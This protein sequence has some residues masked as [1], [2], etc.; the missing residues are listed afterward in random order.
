MTLK[1]I[2]IPAF[3]DNYIWAITDGHSV[4]VVDPGDAEP[5][6]KFCDTHSVCITAILL[7][8]HHEDH[9]GGVSG[10]LSSGRVSSEV[11]VYGPAMEHIEHV[12]RSLQ[13][14][15]LVVVGSPRFS[16]RVLDVP[17]HTSGHI[18]YFQ[19]AGQDGTP[20]LFCG[21]TLFA[22]GCGRLFEGTPQQ[23]LQS[24]D[25]LATLGDATEV[26]CAHEYTLKNIAFSKTCEPSNSAIEVWRKT[27]EA[28]RAAGRPT[29]PTTIGHEKLVNPFLRVEQPAVLVSLADKFGV[30]TLDRLASFS[31]L[32]RWKD[33]F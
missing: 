7:T 21:D 9:V 30:S 14:G 33:N 26:H 8:H 25:T 29:L 23:M 24:L 3:Q 20:H 6:V 16:A 32:R 22:S 17:G 27:A 15:S 28:L 31:L 13:G 19:E 2:P 18:A 11:S 5:V 10:L 1:Y 12:S 4:I